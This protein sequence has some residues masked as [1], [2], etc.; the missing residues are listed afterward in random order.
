[1]ANTNRSTTL[2]EWMEE[3]GGNMT[4]REDASVIRPTLEGDVSAASIRELYRKMTAKDMHMHMW[5]LVRDG[6]ENEK[7]NTKPDKATVFKQM[8]PMLTQWMQQHGYCLKQ[9]NATASKITRNESIS[10]ISAGILI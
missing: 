9:A 2:P 3:A 8:Y 1:M 6:R 5:I 10:E 4:A 7:G